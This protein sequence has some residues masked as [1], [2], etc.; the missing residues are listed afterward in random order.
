[1]A[2]EWTTVECGRDRFNSYRRNEFWMKVPELVRAGY[3]ADSACEQIY[4]GYWQ[5]LSVTAIIKRF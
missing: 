4:S 5:K 1:M 2:K 3:T